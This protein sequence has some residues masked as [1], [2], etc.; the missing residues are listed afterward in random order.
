MPKRNPMTM[1]QHARNG[2]IF[3]QMRADLRR[4][5]MEASSAMTKAHYERAFAK[6]RA[7]IDQVRC[8]L[9][10][11]MC[12]FHPDA[13]LKTYYGESTGGETCA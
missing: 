6:A 12:K 9:D 13:D 5:E 4:I 11:H 10:S 3:K 7:A 8:I 1:E 2:K